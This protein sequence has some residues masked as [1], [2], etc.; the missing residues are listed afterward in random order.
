[1]GRVRRRSGDGRYDT[2]RD[3]DTMR[4]REEVMCG[5]RRDR[6]GVTDT[7]LCEGLPWATARPT[8]HHQVIVADYFRCRWCIRRR[9][10]ILS[11]A[12]SK[13]GEKQVC[14]LH[15][16]DEYETNCQIMYQM[17]SGD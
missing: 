1:V 5:A 16:G 14:S 6:F 15:I 13:L 8:L 7:P 4:A 12:V 3:G 10:V 17:W 9:L 11:N 2:R